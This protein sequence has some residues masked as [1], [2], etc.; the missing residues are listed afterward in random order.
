M[1]GRSDADIIAPGIKSSEIAG[2]QES[3]RELDEDELALVGGGAGGG[4]F[5][6]FARFA[7]SDFGKAIIPGVLG[8][9]VAVA[10]YEIGHTIKE[11]HKKSNDNSN[12]QS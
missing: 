2:E 12:T 10:F 8:A 7:H 6:G 11:A 1:T 5:T 3:L 4:A 9:G